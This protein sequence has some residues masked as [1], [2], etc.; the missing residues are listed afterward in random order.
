MSTVTDEV[1][2]EY[3]DR[4]RLSP[5]DMTGMSCQVFLDVSSYK[6]EIVRMIR[7]TDFCGHPE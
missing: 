5:K 6:I 7:G 2:G 3:F 1:H 4:C